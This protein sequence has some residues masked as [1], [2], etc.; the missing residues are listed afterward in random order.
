MIREHLFHKKAT[1]D[2]DFRWRGGDVSRLEGISDGVF[3]ITITLL[4]VSTA[5]PNNFYDMWLLVRDLPAFIVSYGLIMMAWHYHYLFFRRFG[6]EDPLTSVVNSIFLFIIMFF[7]YPLKFLCTFLW[8]LILRVDVDSMFIVPDGFAFTGLIA[9]LNNVQFQRA[10]MMYLYAFGL[11]GVF[12]SLAVLQIRA[13]RLRDELEL[14]ELERTLTVTAILHHGVNVG[15]GLF[16]VLILYFFKNP[17]AAGIA[18][19][20]LAIYHTVIGAS[21]GRKTAALKKKLKRAA[22]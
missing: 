17:G 22:E 14:D 11:I 2:S 9:G 15:V 5:A 13:L 3:A 20:P 10:G 21:R 6:L 12:G 16:S 1:T 18:Y 4:V 8:H 7:A 19:F